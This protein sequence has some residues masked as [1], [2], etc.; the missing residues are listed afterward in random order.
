MTMYMRINMRRLDILR[1]WAA[2]LEDD[3]IAQDILDTINDLIQTR[4][5]IAKI[6]DSTE[7]VR[8]STDLAWDT[9]TEVHRKLLHLI[10]STGVD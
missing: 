5:T 6:V 10:E 7:L 4:N 8:N 9:R 1:E 2:S 3:P